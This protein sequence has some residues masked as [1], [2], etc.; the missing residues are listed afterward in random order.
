MIYGTP[1]VAWLRARPLRCCGVRLLLRFR[2][3]RFAEI[4]ELRHGDGAPLSHSFTL[5]PHLNAIH[6]F[7]F[8]LQRH[9][10]NDW[11]RRAH[12]RI[13]PLGPT[14]GG[15]I[16]PRDVARLGSRLSGL[17][18]ADHYLQPAWDVRAVVDQ[19]LQEVGRLP[20]TATMAIPALLNDSPGIFVLDMLIRPPRAF[21]HLQ[22]SPRQKFSLRRWLIRQ[23]WQMHPGHR[24]MLMVGDASCD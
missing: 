7:G 15:G 23:F 24:W 4:N 9:L 14:D 5:P 2:G 17:R 6:V 22:I 16:M 8:P 21:P 19:V 20:S 1:L 18:A 10:S 3:Q 12:A 11:A 13:A